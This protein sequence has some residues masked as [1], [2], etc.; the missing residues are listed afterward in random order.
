MSVGIPVVAQLSGALNIYS[1]DLAAFD[2]DAIALAE[3]FA[4]YAAV[5]LAN[6]HLYETTSALAKQMAE[7]MGSR[8]VI[9]QAKGI[10]IAQQGVHP[11]EAFRMLARASQSSNRKLRD[12][13]QA[14]VDGAQRGPGWRRRPEARRFLRP[15]LRL[16]TTR[17]RGIELSTLAA[18]SG[19]SGCVEGPVRDGL[20]ACA[21]AAELA[22]DQP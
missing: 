19:A 20:M 5:A 2:A 1:T 6:A 22:A 9:E 10:L 4:G 21:G 12:I 11:D 14:I 3:A 8:A 15:P 13:A 16:W 17:C 18:P 7:A